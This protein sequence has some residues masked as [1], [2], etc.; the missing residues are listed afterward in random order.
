MVSLGTSIC[1]FRSTP[2]APALVVRTL[3]Q[4][5]RPKDVANKIAAMHEW[6]RIVLMARNVSLIGPD[7]KAGAE[8]RG[9]KTSVPWAGGFL[10][11]VAPLAMPIPGQTQAAWPPRPSV[12]ATGVIFVG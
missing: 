11:F 9:W 8:M 7:C 10:R 2:T 3:S 12:V 6:I 5:P 4:P 1:C